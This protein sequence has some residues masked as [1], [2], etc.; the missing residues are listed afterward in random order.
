MAFDRGTRVNSC[1]PGKR[2]RWLASSG[3]TKQQLPGRRVSVRQGVT[4]RCLY[5]VEEFVGFT[6]AEVML[7][8]I[9]NRYTCEELL[10]EVIMAGF[11]RMPAGFNV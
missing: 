1:R 11:D 8:N 6:L 9:P 7:R 4:T 2:R 10:S 3:M 5:L